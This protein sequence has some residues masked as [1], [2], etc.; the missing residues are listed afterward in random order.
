MSVP[1]NLLLHVCCAPCMVAPYYRLRDEG[2]AVS[3]Y[4]YNPNIHPVTEYRARRDSLR[5]FRAREGFTLIEQ[6]QYGLRDFVKAVA[7]DIDARCAYCYHIRLEAT[8]RM[9]A[10]KGFSAF[11]ST[12]LYSK[13]QRHEIIIET[14]E[15]YAALYNVPFYYRDWRELWQAGI[16]L[17]RAQSMY[18]QK[19]CGCVFSEEDRYLKKK[20][21]K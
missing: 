17:S 14:A 4:W 1:E 8:A 6:D 13:Y 20:E 5:D 16:D 2:I 3:A 10:V 11:S 15:K 19:Y 9:A 7:A 12:L 21:A 18:R